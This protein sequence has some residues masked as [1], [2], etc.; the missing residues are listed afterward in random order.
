MKFIRNSAIALSP[1]IALLIVGFI[2]LNRA[3]TEAAKDKA[4]FLIVFS[5]VYLVMVSSVVVRLAWDK[6]PYSKQELGVIRE[7]I[8]EVLK[9]RATAGTDQQTLYPE[10]YSGGLDRLSFTLRTIDEREWERI[11][12]V[13]GE[14]KAQE[15]EAMESTLSKQGDISQHPQFK[16]IQEDIAEL[17][18]QLEALARA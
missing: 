15:I 1:L 5:I 13:H 4:L 9:W 7:H 6:R 18:R 8:S 2:T 14:A 11:Y 3:T 12:R 10:V 16:K 17:D